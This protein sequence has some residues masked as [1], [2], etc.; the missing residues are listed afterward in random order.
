MK[1]LSVLL[2][3]NNF[4]HDGPMSRDCFVKRP[5]GS[6]VVWPIKHKA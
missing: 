1:V 3:Q 2:F 5:G 4:E 6:A